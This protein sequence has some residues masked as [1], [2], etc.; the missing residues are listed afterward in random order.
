M[1]YNS[2]IIVKQKNCKCGC[3]RIGFIFSKGLVKECWSRLYGKN[4]PKVSDKRKAEISVVSVDKI[5]NLEQ[6]FKDRH[7]EMKGVCQHCQGKTQKGKENYKCSI[8]HIFQK[9]YF[10]S[11]AT[12]PLNWIELCFYGNSCHQNFDNKMIN[13]T[14]LNCFDDVIEKFIKMYPSIAKEEK[15]RIPNILM[16]YVDNK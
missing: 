3:G 14:E 9:T 8:G 5:N 12:H 16:Q 6:W 1:P 4:I 10:K 11:I 13:I 15:R 7:A 2:T